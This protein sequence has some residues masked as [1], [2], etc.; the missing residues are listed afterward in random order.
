V[1]QPSKWCDVVS[2]N[3]VKRQIGYSVY[4]EG[5][6]MFCFSNQFLFAD[7]IWK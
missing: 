4:M 1:E 3:C 2:V 5:A 6:A 7:D